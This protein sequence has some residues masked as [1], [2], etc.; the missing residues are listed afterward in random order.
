M[1]SSLPD[2]TRRRLNEALASWNKWDTDL[3]SQPDVL[4][5]LGGNN[6]ESFLVESNGQKLV[7][8]LNLD[9]S[10]LGVD[11]NVERQVL[12]DIRGKTFAPPIV[13]LT[14]EFL[15]TEYVA[16]STE[17]LTAIDL[18]ALIHDIRKTRTSISGVLDPI[19]HARGFLEQLTLDDSRGQLAE[20]ALSVAPSAM[21]TP[22]LCHNDLN[23]G[24]IIKGDNRVVAIDWEYA[25][26]APPEFEIAVVVEAHELDESDR[27]TLIEA[28]NAKNNDVLHMQQ[29]FR[30]IESLWWERKG[31]SSPQAWK[32]LEVLLG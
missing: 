25:S 16:A 14:D 22:C 23:P 28:L 29:L 15:V 11:R 4:E 8:R 18:A 21:S 24:N 30:L 20:R 19:A 9:N 32:R 1:A 26:L 5:Q 13:A 2:A 7:V 27:R 6:N 10:H 3:T 17:P 12:M 31:E